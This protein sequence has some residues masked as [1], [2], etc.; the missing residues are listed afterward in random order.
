M[1]L[2]VI[3]FLEHIYQF[4]IEKRHYL[5]MA[6]NVM[7]LTWSIMSEKSPKHSDLPYRTYCFPCMHVAEDLTARIL[8][9]I[10]VCLFLKRPLC[11]WTTWLYFD[12]SPSTWICFVSPG[13]GGHGN[14]SQVTRMRIADPNKHGSHEELKLEAE[15]EFHRYILQM[16]NDTLRYILF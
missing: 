16:C 4:R 12:S 8:D 10:S 9:W 7:I 13:R 5:F 3:Y 15:A 11:R 1:V 14:N 2:I 6:L